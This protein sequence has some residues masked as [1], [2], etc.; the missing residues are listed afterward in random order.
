MKIRRP[1]GSELRAYRRAAKVSQSKA[2][3]LVHLGSPQRWSEYERD[4]RNIDSA[5]F[6][7]FLIKTGQHD[8]FQHRVAKPL[9]G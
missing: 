4:E 6:E 9:F 2:S 8:D 3:A 1:T 7:L 5:R